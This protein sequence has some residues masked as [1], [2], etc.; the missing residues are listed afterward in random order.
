VFQG[1]DIFYL[2]GEGQGEGK[3]RGRMGTA[4]LYST[5]I[6]VDIAGTGSSNNV[7]QTSASSPYLKYRNKTICHKK[8]QHSFRTYMCVSTIFYI[9][10][11][12]YSVVTEINCTRMPC[13][14]FVFYEKISLEILHILIASITVHY[15]GILK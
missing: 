15:F 8:C 5:E 3:A 11:N 9:A 2:S 4:P 10:S 7:Y 12:I 1:L 13:C 14:Y 6:R